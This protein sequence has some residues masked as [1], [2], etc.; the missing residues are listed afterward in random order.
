MYG[1]CRYFLRNELVEDSTMKS[2][3]V[4]LAEEQLLMLRL[5]DDDIK[6][7]RIISQE[8]LDSDDMEWLQEV[9]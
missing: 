5:S 3:A 9:P 1:N 2:D 8:Q 6:T 7:G 4:K